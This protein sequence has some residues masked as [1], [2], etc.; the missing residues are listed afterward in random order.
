MGHSEVS[1]SPEM[2]RLK[3]LEVV[4]EILQGL[5]ITVGLGLL[6][7]TEAV[8]DHLFRL[9]DRVNVRPRTRPVSAFP[10]GQPRKRPPRR[11]H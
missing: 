9:L 11:A 2:V 3:P 4:V 5:G 10:P 1:E 8:R 7:M 6:W